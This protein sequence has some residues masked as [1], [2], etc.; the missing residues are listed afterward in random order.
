MPNSARIAWRIYTAGA[1][2]GVA[3]FLFTNAFFRN[4]QMWDDAF[5]GAVCAVL[6]ISIMYQRELNR[7]ETN[8]RNSWHF[9]PPW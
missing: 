4:E 5:G 1:L 6:V 8:G 9:A 7:R 3:S 2:V